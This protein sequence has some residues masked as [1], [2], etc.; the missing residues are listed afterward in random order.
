MAEGMAVVKLRLFCFNP[1]RLNNIT[2]GESE[3]ANAMKTDGKCSTP[4]KKFIKMNKEKWKRERCSDGF[5]N[6]V[7]TLNEAQEHMHLTKAQ[8]ITVSLFPSNDWI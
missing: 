1:L 5:F 3:Q 6:G 2:Q 4:E 8:H 7:F